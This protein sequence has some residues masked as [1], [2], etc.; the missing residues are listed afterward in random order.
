LL[1]QGSQV[2]CA[3]SLLDQDSDLFLVKAAMDVD[4][5]SFKPTT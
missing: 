3:K 5:A 1:N 2:E 4:G